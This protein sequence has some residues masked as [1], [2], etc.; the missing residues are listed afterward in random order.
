MLFLCGQVASGSD[1]AERGTQ[2]VDTLEIADTIVFVD[3]I[4][5]IRTDELKRFEAVDNKTNFEKELAQQPTVALLKS[6]AIPGLGQYGNG[7]KIKG[8]FFFALD[9]WFVSS[10]LKYKGQTSDLRESYEQETS[11]SSRNDFY[12][13]F[14]NKRDQRNKFTWFAVIVTFVSMFDAY[15]DAHLSGFP[16]RP[17]GEGSGIM[18]GPNGRG[19][20]SANLVLRF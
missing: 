12:Q 7:K 17:D 2:E 13:K 9:A 8:L 4:T 6:M 19:D 10:A 20:L 11:I 5:Y 15:A 18:I 16:I 1:E 14:Q 3:T